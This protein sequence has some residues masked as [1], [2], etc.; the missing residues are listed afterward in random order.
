M[1][2]PQAEVQTE[3]S[4]QLVILPTS[5]IYSSDKADLWRERT[6]RELPFVVCRKVGQRFKSVE[7]PSDLAARLADVVS[8][9]RSGRI[10]RHQVFETAES[11]QGEFFER[12]NPD[13]RR[14]IESGENVEIRFKTE[15]GR[16]VQGPAVPDEP[17]EQSFVA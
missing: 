7:C 6:G 9:F 13:Q 14:D 12:M 4:G 10:S 2:L 11:L 1:K 17:S 3:F 15:R 8:Q 5:Y 16:P